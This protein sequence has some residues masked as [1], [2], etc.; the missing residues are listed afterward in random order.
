MNELVLAYFL[1]DCGPLYITQRVCHDLQFLQMP[2]P[3]AAEKPKC[4][5]IQSISARQVKSK[6]LKEVWEILQYN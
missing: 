3:L 5:A 4:V 2:K 1:V 6:I